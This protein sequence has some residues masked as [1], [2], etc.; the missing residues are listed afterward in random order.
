M[1]VSCQG[2]RCCSV[3]LESAK[4]RRSNKQQQCQSLPD[5]HLSYESCQAAEEHLQT[6]KKQNK[7][8]FQE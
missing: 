6:V 1:N 3:R 2:A 7:R 4:N 8:S 5:G